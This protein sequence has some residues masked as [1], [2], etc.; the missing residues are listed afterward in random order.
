LG[1][2]PGPTLT[3]NNISSTLNF[4]ANIKGFKIACINVNSLMKHIDEIRFILTST[5][6][7][8]LA[9]NESKL[10]NSIN[11]GEIHIHGYVSIRKDR[12]R[13]GGGVLIYIKENLVYSN[14]SDLVPYRLEMICLEIKSSL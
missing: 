13:H 9:I 7:E 14:R 12:T 4:F 2:N 8:V 1:T 11:D 5:T 6:L 3:D 10:D